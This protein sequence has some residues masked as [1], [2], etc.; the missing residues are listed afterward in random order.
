MDKYSPATIKIND[1]T[2]RERLLKYIPLYKETNAEKYRAKES[3]KTLV[4][5]FM[6]FH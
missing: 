2:E 6:T 3:K 4:I 5:P 1:N